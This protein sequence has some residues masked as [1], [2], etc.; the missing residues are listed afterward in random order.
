[1]PADIERRTSRGLD[2]L[3]AGVCNARI[4]NRAGRC[5]RAFMAAVRKAQK[6]VGGAEGRR[7]QLGA[8]GAQ[9]GGRGRWRSQGDTDE[10]GEGGPKCEWGRGR[11]S[12]RT[13]KSRS[14]HAAEPARQ[15]RAHRRMHSAR[16]GPGSGKRR[17]RRAMQAAATRGATAARA[18]VPAATAAPSLRLRLLRGGS[19]SDKWGTVAGSNVTL[20]A[21][22][23]PGTTTTTA[24]MA[25][26]VLKFKVCARRRWHRRRCC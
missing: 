8:Q 14:G 19:G 5:M 24:T 9:D 15:E 20:F 17:A 7:E 2:G 6:H 25:P 12:S 16:C 3:I 26:F 10:G 21:R 1:M 18:G 22:R 4:G 11:R 23:A 13:G